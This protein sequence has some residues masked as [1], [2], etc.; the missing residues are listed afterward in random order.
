MNKFNKGDSVICI[1]PI[2][3]YLELGK[4]YVVNDYNS[5]Y[6]L[7]PQ[8]VLAPDVTGGFHDARFIKVD[9]LTNLEKVIYG[10]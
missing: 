5:L 6:S 9:K 8:L 1:D 4:I 2:P 3:T 7:Y 10:L